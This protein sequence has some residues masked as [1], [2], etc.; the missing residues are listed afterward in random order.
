MDDTGNS[1]LRMPISTGT[2]NDPGRTIS[3]SSCKQTVARI[4]ISFSFLALFWQ[5]VNGLM[6]HLQPRAHARHTCGLKVGSVSERHF[7]ARG[8]EAIEGEMIWRGMIFE[9]VS[10]LVPQP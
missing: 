1:G 4:T 3:S 7:E 6:A 2:R 10:G 8:R 5:F 9:S